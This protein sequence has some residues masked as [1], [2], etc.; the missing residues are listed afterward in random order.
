MRDERLSFK[1]DDFGRGTATA[2][3]SIEMGIDWKMERTTISK[4][5]P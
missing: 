3:E 4:P 5:N 1:T 2:K